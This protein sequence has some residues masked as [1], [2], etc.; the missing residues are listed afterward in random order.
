M[1]PRL[2]EARIPP[3]RALLGLTGVVIIALACDSSCQIEHVKFCPGMAQQVGEV[4]E[5]FTVL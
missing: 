4:P 3:R 2:F 1:A 5:P